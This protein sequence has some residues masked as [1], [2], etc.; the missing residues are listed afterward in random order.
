MHAP[1]IRVLRKKLSTKDCVWVPLVSIYLDCL[2][3]VH[4][5]VSGK[6]NTIYEMDKIMARESL[7]FMLYTES[8]SAVA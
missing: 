8:Y 3:R 1:L 5:L 6:V 4:Y 7:F 2:T